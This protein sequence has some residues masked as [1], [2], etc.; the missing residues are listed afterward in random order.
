MHSHEIIKAMGV[1]EMT[2]YQL[3]T[4]LSDYK[5]FDIA[6]IRGVISNGIYDNTAKLFA[7]CIG[8]TKHF[9]K[10][11]KPEKKTPIITPRQTSLNFKP[12]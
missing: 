4:K 7:Y 11:W 6:F 8:A 2:A 9:P 3:R 1:S 10:G 5:V 12:V